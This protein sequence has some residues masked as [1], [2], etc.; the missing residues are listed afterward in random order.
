MEKFP[1]YRCSKFHLI[2]KR[3][4]T[5]PAK[6]SC[7]RRVK[8]KQFMTDTSFL[9]AK[10]QEKGTD[11]LTHRPSSLFRYTLGND[12]R[13]DK[14]TWKLNHKDLLRDAG[15][16]REVRNIFCAQSS[17]ESRPWAIKGGGGG[18]A[19]VFL[20]CWNKIDLRISL[21]LPAFL[22]SAFFYYFIIIFFAGGGPSP[23][24]ATAKA[25][26]KSTKAYLCILMDWSWCPCIAIMTSASSSTNIL[27]FLGST[28]LCLK[29]KSN[30]VPG[31]ANKMW[32]VTLWPSDTEKEKNSKI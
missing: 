12:P 30:I 16:S 28:A 15:N 3:R 18:G 19:A 1:F 27:I 8:R 5:D 22:L 13:H 9:K 21:A 14:T 10:L 17:G 23:R 32:S 7:P 29:I 11:H 6:P 31:V 24:S 26:S 2:Y 20:R 25:T 4:F